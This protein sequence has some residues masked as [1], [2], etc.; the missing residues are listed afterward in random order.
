MID[1]VVARYGEPLDWLQRFK[2]HSDFRVMVYNKGPPVDCFAHSIVSRPNSGREAETWLYH[3]CSSYDTLAD[4]TI[5]LQGN[6][7]DHTAIPLAPE[8][9][10]RSTGPLVPL[11]PLYSEHANAFPLVRSREYADFLFHV[12]PDVFSFSP[13]AQYIVSRETLQ[14]R[15]LAFYTR[16]HSMCLAETATT[17]LDRIP[18]SPDTIDAWTLERLWPLLWE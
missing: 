5:F 10:R 16:L 3:I 4:H 17:Y 2:D 13:G 11:H 1:L 6:P 8:V 7:V 12:S 14:R 9:L 15:S 18:F